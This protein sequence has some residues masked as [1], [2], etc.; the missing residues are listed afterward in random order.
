MENYNTKKELY[1]RLIASSDIRGE[2][3]FFISP[4]LETP[5]EYGE[6]LEDSLKYFEDEDNNKKIQESYRETIS[7]C[8]SLYKSA[9]EELDKIFSSTNDSSTND[10]EIP[11]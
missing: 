3:R 7:Y 9:K 1:F 10:I 8:E 2:K 6:V 4:S 11:F 5:E